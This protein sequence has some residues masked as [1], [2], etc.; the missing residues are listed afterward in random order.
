MSTENYLQIYDDNVVKFTIKQ[1]SE[2]DRWPLT[3]DYK[4][5]HSNSN[6]TY[7]KYENT[8][9]IIEQPSDTMPGAF[10]MAELAFTRD[11]NR[12]FAGNFSNTTGETQKTVGGSLV[13]NKYLG[14][15]DSKKLPTNADATTNGKPLQLS[16]ANSSG[17]LEE[18]SK[19]RCYF[20][21]DS[22]GSDSKQCEETEDGCWPK[23]AY[24]NKKYDAYDGD[25]MYDIYRNALIIFDHN[26]QPSIPASNGSQINTNS[27]PSE[28]AAKNTRHTT[29]LIPYNG[30]DAA[31]KDFT[32]DM[33][34]DGYVLLYNV[35]PDG[36]TLTF[37]EKKFEKTSGIN[38]NN[39]GNYSQ[40]II[41]LK[42]IPFNKIL[43]KLDGNYFKD[44]G[45]GIITL[46]NISSAGGGGINISSNSSLYKIYNVK[47]AADTIMA[48]DNS[49]YIIANS[50]ISYSNLKTIIDTDIPAIKDDIEGLKESSGGSGGVSIEDLNA[51]KI[52]VKSLI[53][54]AG[55]FTTA[56][57]I[58][59]EISEESSNENG[60]Y[61]K[62][63][64]DGK[65]NVDDFDSTTKNGII[66]IV[67]NKTFV[68]PYSGALYINAYPTGASTSQPASVHVVRVSNLVDP[69]TGE[70]TGSTEEAFMGSM[71]MTN[72]TGNTLCVPLE[73]GIK[74]KIYTT[75]MPNDY[76]P[77]SNTDTSAGWFYSWICFEK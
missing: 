16:S 5:D 34:G 6:T 28:S 48:T 4:I 67:S 30:G 58:I 65:I 75:N 53:S 55:K 27:L 51:F 52:E 31:V 25:Y 50:G 70:E 60:T 15:V 54:N 42:D 22:N 3:G 18:G 63:G 26:I 56:L 57:R 14:F 8:T 45:N 2:N 49:G 61:I 69:D 43:E 13:G 76:I 21:I 62:P 68:A 1:G 7:L 20:H 47:A 9:S 33:Y 24:Y 40:N 41:K 71:L 23:Q 77:K 74:Y 32:S 19:L 46:Q 38:S 10:T 37:S 59:K 66:S 72:K 64:T 36:E 12:V 11:T 17:L 39:P 29:P 44:S 35:I 73:L